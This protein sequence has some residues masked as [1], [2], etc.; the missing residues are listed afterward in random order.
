MKSMTSNVN[1]NLIFKLLWTISICDILILI[2]LFTLS[3]YFSQN[4]ANT[5]LQHAFAYIAFNFSTINLII[6]L[7]LIS[8]LMIGIY[9]LQFIQKQEHKDVDSTITRLVNGEETDYQP[10]RKNDRQQAAFPSAIETLGERKAHYFMLLDVTATATLTIDESQKIVQFNQAAQRLFGYE[11]HEIL[12]RSLATLLPKRY[13]KD[14]HKK[15]KSFDKSDKEFVN[16]REGSRVSGLRKNGEEFPI[17]LDITKVE[18]KSEKLFIA[19]IFDISDRLVQQEKIAQQ[20]LELKQNNQQ[21]KHYQKMLEETVHERNDE[22]ELSTLSLNAATQQLIDAEKMVA[23]GQMVSSAAH[24][25]NTPIGI[26]VTCASNVLE[27]TTSLN[28]RIN[29]NQLTKNDLTSYMAMVEQSAKIILSNME[30]AAELVHSFKAV[31]SDQVTDMQRLFNLNEYLE[32]ILLSLNPRLGKTQHEVFITCDDNIVLDT[33]PG[34]L[35]QIIINLIMNSLIHGFEQM[36]HGTI[37]LAIKLMGGDLE[38][39]YKDN[40]KGLT[41]EQ[42]NKLF[43]PFYTTKRDE[44]GTGLGMHIVEDLVKNSLGGQIKLMPS[45]EGICFKLTFPTI[46]KSVEA[47]EQPLANK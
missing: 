9:F 23:L 42:A 1:K 16:L 26:G 2:T 20:T 37:R 21:L 25:I 43:D 45:E 34:P 4:Q 22:L 13:R 24:E 36:D 8:A 30:R 47:T 27:A 6:G 38:L 19:A 15:V 33:K 5:Q 46:L 10:A 39:I 3:E 31:S 18:I 14:H 29:N 41:E 44:G 11:K 17:E 12:D 40:G 35:S 28:G 7:M 32:E